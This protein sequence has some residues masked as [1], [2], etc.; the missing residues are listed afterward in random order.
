MVVVDQKERYRRQA[1]LCYDIAAKMT[2]AKAAAMIHL[3]D[4]YAALAV[5]PDRPPPNIYVPND[6]LAQPHCKKCGRKMRLA[7]SLPRTRTLPLMQ[8]FRCDRCG[9]MLIWK[10]ATPTRRSADELPARGPPRE[11]TQWVTRHVAISFRRVGQRFSPGEAIECPDARIAV[12][13]AQLMMRDREI[14]GAV[15][16]SR[17]ANA[18]SGEVEGAAILTKLGTIPDGFDIA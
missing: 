18:A 2:P 13:R 14:A 1:A 10:G 7:Y 9:E 15:A 16:F 12:R 6:R 8:A 4:T 3:G 11:G 17:R 5:D